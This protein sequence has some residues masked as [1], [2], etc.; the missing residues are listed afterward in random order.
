[1]GAASPASA[2]VV[3]SPP[4]VHH[5][6][7]HNGVEVLLA[8]AG[9]VFLGQEHDRAVCLIR[10][11]DALRETKCSEA[12]TTSSE[13]ATWTVVLASMSWREAWTSKAASPVVTLS[14]PNR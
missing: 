14:T 12:A 1:M 4:L 11:P 10:D 5:S 8:V 9:V 7:Q 3:E 2:D 6:L 13:L